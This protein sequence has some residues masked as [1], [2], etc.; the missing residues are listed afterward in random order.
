MSAPLEAARNFLEESGDGNAADF[1]TIGQ[2][3]SVACA[4]IKTCEGRP[5]ADMMRKALH[6]YAGYYQRTMAMEDDAPG[7]E[8]I[9]QQR[10]G[11]GFAIASMDRD[12]ITA[13]LADTAIVGAAPVGEQE[14]ILK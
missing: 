9:C 14:R 8:R 13:A 12:K 11:L 5:D 6:R 1:V 10:D 4:Y 3:K 2:L 7:I